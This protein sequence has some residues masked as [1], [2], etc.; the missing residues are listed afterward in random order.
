M[1]TP[2]TVQIVPTGQAEP[3]PNDMEQVLKAQ[4]PLFENPNKADYL[5]NRAC[6]FSIRESAALA[7]VQQRTISDWRRN[8]PEFARWEG[9][10]LIYLQTN[11]ITIVMRAKFMRCMML[12]MIIDGKVLKKAAFAGLG[13]LTERENDYLIKLAG[14]NYNPQALLA[15]E[16]A[17]GEVP[18]SDGDTNIS[19]G[20]AVIVVDGKEV[21]TVEARQAAAKTLLEQFTANRSKFLSEDEEP[22]EGEVVKAQRS[23]GNGN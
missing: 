10:R 8:D 23:D 11:L 4:L 5:A 16:R 3:N 22:L 12:G 2:D 19:V 14:K 20:Q 6:G 17:C 18:D 21:T 9:E 13:N 1:E 7:H 15:L